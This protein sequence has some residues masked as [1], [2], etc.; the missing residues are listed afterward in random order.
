VSGNPIE[1]TIAAI[2]TP[3]GVGGIAIIRI[4]GPRALQIADALFVSNVGR[5]SRFQSHT[6]HFGR[7]TANGNSVDH[8]LLSV[9][10]SPHSYT[11][12]D[13]VEINC[14]GGLLVTRRVLALCLE[15]G[16]R[17]AEAGEFTK[18]A[19]LNGRL[20]LTQAEAVM[21]LIQAKSDRA[22]TAAQQ[23]LDGHLSRKIDEARNELLSVIAHIEAH[24]DFPDEDIEPAN[25][26]MWLGRVKDAISFLERLIDSAREGKVLRHG[27]SVTIVGR[28][29]A[30]KSSL[31]NAL[32]GEDRAIVT[33]VPGTTRDTIEELTTISGIPIKLTDTAGIRKARGTVEAVGIDRSR[34][35]LA[36]CDLIL[37]V[38]DGSRRLSG[39]DRL[40]I[41]LC[42]DRPVIQVTNKCDLPQLLRLPAENL[43][44]HRVNI[45]A[46]TGAG[47]ATLK[48]LIESVAISKSESSHEFHAFVNER[49]A[50]ALTRAQF[51]LTASSNY[52]ANGSPP[53]L[54][55]QELRIALNAIGEVL[56]ST[57][58]E[59]ILDRVFSNFCIGK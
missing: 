13:T 55:S 35:S 25:R 8:V 20:D 47:I 58:T 24:I 21:D 19:F 5:P 41:S 27:I 44:P 16:A 32:L 56:G 30:G 53:E 7:I 11:T 43:S 37:N 42:T 48:N 9:M 52:I 40:L 18:R 29:N 46:K 2:S 49:Q 38:F 15:H 3:I 33:P 22:Q 45:S 14:H 23:A 6:I 28:P 51:A 1:D 54:F 34:I 26:E 10:H 31:M 17:L 57:S 4:S 50:D 36:R 39:D 12:E 59:D